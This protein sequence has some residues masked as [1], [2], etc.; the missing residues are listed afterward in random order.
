M[1]A[2]SWCCASESGILVT[3]DLINNGL[4]CWKTSRCS[5]RQNAVQN[6]LDGCAKLKCFFQTWVAKDVTGLCNTAHQN[7]AK[8]LPSYTAR[9]IGVIINWFFKTVSFCLPPWEE[10]PL[11]GGYN[12]YCTQ[13]PRTGSQRRCES[14]RSGSSNTAEKSGQRCRP[15]DKR[16]RSSPCHLAE[17]K[18]GQDLFPLPAALAA[19]DIYLVQQKGGAVCPVGVAP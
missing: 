15:C 17:H 8:V 14:V 9:Q 12:S 16:D 2:S 11:F 7:P 19:V 4:P 13:L 3:S 1:R 10:R 5:L 6:L 18:D